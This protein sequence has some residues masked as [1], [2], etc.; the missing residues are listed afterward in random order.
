[1]DRHIVVVVTVLLG[2]FA[3]AGLSYAAGKDDAKSLGKQAA[4]YVK[5]QGKGKALAEI[6]KPKG[7]FATRARPMSSPTTCRGS[8]L[9]TRKIRH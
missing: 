9:P 7:M 6:S 5:Y 4:A 1:M 3:F 2:F 8:W